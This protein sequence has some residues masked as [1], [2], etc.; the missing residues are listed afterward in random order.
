MDQKQT[1]LSSQEPVQQESIDQQP[2]EQK[3]S[4]W[5]SKNPATVLIR[6]LLYIF[7]GLPLV[8]V[9]ATIIW[10]VVWKLVSR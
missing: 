6:I 3:A 4:F 7:V 2:A 8:G 9:L 10:L 5:K 1:N